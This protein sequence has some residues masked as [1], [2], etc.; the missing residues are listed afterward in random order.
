MANAIAKFVDLPAAPLVDG[1]LDFEPVF[2][3]TTAQ[4]A[5]VIQT[6]RGDISRVGYDGAEPIEIMSVDVGKTPALMRSVALDFFPHL[7]PG[8]SIVLNQDYVFPFQP[9][10]AMAMEMLS[11]FF[12]LEFEPPTECTTVH[13]LTRA[14]TRADVEARLSEDF[15]KVEN[16]NSLARAAARSVSPEVKLTMRAAQIHAYWQLG[17]KKTAQHVAG[18]MLT[19][20]SLLAVNVDQS[21]KLT[22][23]FD[24]IGVLHQLKR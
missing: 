4:Y 17:L 18:Q 10:V 3:H 14:I 7:I 24:Q 16:L 2:R 23:L 19:E 1:K 8:K 11:D 9:W 5:H 13:R 22:R 6:R 20:H 21:A 15:Y 12:V